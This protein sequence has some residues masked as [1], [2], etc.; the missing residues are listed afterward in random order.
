MVHSSPL[1]SVQMGEEEEVSLEEYK[2]AYG[3]TLGYLDTL[4][5]QEDGTNKEEEE[6]EREDLATQFPTQK[7]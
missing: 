5:G 7:P 6:E 1:A 2:E 3:D 4:G